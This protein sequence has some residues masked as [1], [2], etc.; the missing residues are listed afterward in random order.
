L[1]QRD[2][3]SSFPRVFFVSI[4][5]VSTTPNVNPNVNHAAAEEEGE[6]KRE[7]NYGSNDIQELNDHKFTLI[8]HSNE[9]YQLVQGYVAGS[10]RQT[11]EGFGLLSHQA[12]LTNEFASSTGFERN[13]VKRLLS[14]LTKFIEDDRFSSKNYED[15]FGVYLKGGGEEYYPTI[16]HRELLDG[17]IKNGGEREIGELLEMQI[18]R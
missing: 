14:Y 9:Q 4:V 2:D 12:S 3:E 1:L 16:T 6:V 5:W 17:D 15:A 7:K 10:G 18:K 13:G 11:H 8:K